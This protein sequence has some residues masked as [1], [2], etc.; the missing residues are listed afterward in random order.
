MVRMRVP[1]R[2]GLRN[3][4]RDLL[5]LRRIELAGLQR[6][7]ELQ[8]T[9]ENN[10]G[11]SDA[12]HHVRGEAGLSARHREKTFGYIAGVFE[13]NGLNSLHKKYLLVVQPF[14]LFFGLPTLWM[15]RASVSVVDYGGQVLNNFTD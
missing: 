8:I 11:L 14:P 4:Q 10:G 5:T 2:I 6:A 12:P 3:S 15:T 13:L 7:A 1:P 9:F